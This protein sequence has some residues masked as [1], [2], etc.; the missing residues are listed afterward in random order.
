MIVYEWLC[1][2]PKEQL[3]FYLMLLTLS[4]LGDPSKAWETWAESSP[5][6]SAQAPTYNHTVN[7]PLLSKTLATNPKQA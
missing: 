5:V 3:L 1:E 7:L 2:S 6:G 4:E